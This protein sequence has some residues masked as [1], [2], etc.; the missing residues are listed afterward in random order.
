MLWPTPRPEEHD[1]TRSSDAFSRRRVV[2]AIDAMIATVTQKSSGC[3]KRAGL[4]FMPM[5]PA[6][7][8]PAGRPPMRASS[9]TISFVRCPVLAIR[10]SNDP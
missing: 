9:F 8:A 6:I 3:V 2:T 5:I 10:T 7:S 1:L 4:K